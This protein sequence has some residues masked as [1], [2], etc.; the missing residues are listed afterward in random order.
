M[1]IT[2]WGFL[3]RALAAIGFGP[4]TN[5]ALKEQWYRNEAY[6]L[7]LAAEIK[8]VTDMP[9]FRKRPVMVKAVQ[10]FPG[11]VIEGVVERANG[12]Y[13]Y[14]QTLAGNHIVDPGDWV[15]TGTKGEK[16]PCKPDIFELTHEL[17]EEG[18]TCLS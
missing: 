10:W 3:G 9:N 13:G 5:T 2:I 17:V 18:L 4:P 7:A 11:V 6:Q 1:P 14:I 12:V 8:R 15:I 16:Y